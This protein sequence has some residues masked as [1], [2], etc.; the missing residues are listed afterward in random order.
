MSEF[1]E[2][3]EEYNKKNTLPSNVVSLFGD[4]LNDTSQEGGTWLA[5]LGSVAAATAVYYAKKTKDQDAQEDVP[6]APEKKKQLMKKNKVNPP[7]QK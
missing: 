5:A 3:L 4:Q 1:T 6:V 2:N 7:Q